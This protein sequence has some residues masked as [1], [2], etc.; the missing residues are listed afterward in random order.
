MGGGS[1]VNCDGN[2]FGGN[3]CGGG[4]G[5]EVSKVVIFGVASV[6][7]VFILVMTILTRVEVLITLKLVMNEGE[8]FV[9]GYF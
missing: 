8:E 3:G 5:N 4:G 6:F 7:M 9:G 2:N 1:F